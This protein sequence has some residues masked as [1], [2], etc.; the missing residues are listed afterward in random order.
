MFSVG[1]RQYVNG[2]K[3]WFLLFRELGD[4]VRNRCGQ[5]HDM[6]FSWTVRGV[7][8]H[9]PNIIKKAPPV[10]I[11]QARPLYYPTLHMALLFNSNITN[12]WVHLTLTH[13]THW[14]VH[15]D[16]LL[17]RPSITLSALPNGHV[18]INMLCQRFLPPKV[19]QDK[20]PSLLQN[21]N[22]AVP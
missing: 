19:T 8:M 1:F 2:S 21:K 3:S 13:G 16:V 5:A 14:V 15:I 12:F 7:C 4:C 9:P 6:K 18:R 10:D 22:G 20:H 11:I 17:A